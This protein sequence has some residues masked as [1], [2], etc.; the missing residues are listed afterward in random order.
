MNPLPLMRHAARLVLTLLLLAAAPLAQAQQGLFAPRL[1]IND[2]VITE[3]EFGQRVLFLQ[4]LRAP[5]DPEQQAL[6]GLIEDRLR[7][8]AAK[9]LK[10]IDSLTS[11]E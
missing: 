11:L 5:G 8:D 10:I 3:Y 2:S 9:A 4:L 1:Y 7:V 6:D